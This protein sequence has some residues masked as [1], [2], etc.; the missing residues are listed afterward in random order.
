MRNVS[1]LNGDRALLTRFKMLLDRILKYN[2]RSVFSCKGCRSSASG[3]KMDQTDRLMIMA[4]AKLGIEP[5]P[6]GDIPGALQLSYLAF[7]D[8]PGLLSM[9]D[10]MSNSFLYCGS[11]CAI[12][13]LVAS[14]RCA[15]SVSAYA[16]LAWFQRGWVI[17][18]GGCAGA[19]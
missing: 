7:G 18:M 6:L 4:L 15:S 13:G 16:V 12:M 8:Q 17:I 14:P 9:T 1:T 11:G 10:C 19:V 3:K 2:S 5:R